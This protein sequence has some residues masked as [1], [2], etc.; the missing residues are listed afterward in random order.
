MSA[1]GFVR[2][3][4][5]AC[6][7]FSVWPSASV[8]A[9][10]SGASAREPADPMERARV[11]F[12][13]GVDFY[14]E[15][16]YRAA[17]IEFQ[18]A[19]DATPHYKLLYNLGQ[20]SLELQE[21]ER[22]IEYFQ[23]Y[24]S[25]GAD[26]LD[27]ERR[28]EVEQT[29][30]RL[31]ERLATVQIVTNQPGAQIYLDEMSIGTAP[32]AE[33]LNVSVG[34]RRFVAVKPG[35]PNVERVIDVA[36]G[37]ELTVTLEF[38]QRIEPDASQ[39]AMRPDAFSNRKRVSP[40][41]WTGIATGGLALTATTLSI[42]TLIAQNDYDDEKKVRTTPAKL[43]SLRDDAKVKALLADCLWGAT[44]AGAAVTVVL[45]TTAKD[46]EQ[47]RAAVQVQP[48]GVRVVGAF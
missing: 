39:V 27:P 29:I 22:A 28:S 33:P 1:V 11:H 32:L 47:V 40:A 13:L 25:E 44:L 2:V 24:L 4:L 9:Q 20:A 31:T 8:G 42:L 6:A 5:I 43:A 18:R 48:T 46:G 10:S 38:K 16:N 12:K 17:L 37:D 23:R 21:D 41:V 30:A 15:R 26:K 36:A 45:L 34:R 35:F 3:A 7:L 19:Y 14:R